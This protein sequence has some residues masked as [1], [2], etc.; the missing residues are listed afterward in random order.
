MCSIATRDRPSG[1]RQRIMPRTSTAAPVSGNL[2]HR[3]TRLRLPQRRPLPIRD[4][5]LL[6]TGEKPMQLTWPEITKLLRN[7]AERRGGRAYIRDNVVVLSTD[8]DGATITVRDLAPDGTLIDAGWSLQIAADAEVTDNEPPYFLTIVEAIMD[9]T[10]E[11]WAIVNPDNGTWIDTGVN[12]WYPT[13][14]TGAHAGDQP[15]QRPHF[16]HRLPAW[17]RA[18]STP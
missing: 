9:G 15:D 5:D 8:G 14:R 6:G 1:L 17:Q 3:R 2:P 11:E 4:L 12:V 7:A 13:G 18:T 16:V 10:A